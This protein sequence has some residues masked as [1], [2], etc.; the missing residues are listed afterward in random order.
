MEYNNNSE[1]KERKRQTYHW[2][3]SWNFSGKIYYTNYKQNCH[4]ISE[5][6][7]IP[8]DDII[9]IMKNVVF[10][11]M[12]SEWNGNFERNCNHVIMLALYFPN[13]Q[14]E[15]MFFGSF[16]IFID[17][18]NH[19]NHYGLE[20]VFQTKITSHPTKS[21]KSILFTSCFMNGER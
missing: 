11:K 13:P 9:Y 18:H 4:C 8:S 3:W 16:A 12:A 14:F 2:S 20:W 7:T 10:K 6:G 5:T 19:T 17:I 21:T 15:S 1:A